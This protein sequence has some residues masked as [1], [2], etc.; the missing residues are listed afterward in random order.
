MYINIY[1]RIITE[2]VIL[3]ESLM[4]Q[5]R[6]LFDRVVVLVF[7]IFIMTSSIITQRLNAPIFLHPAYRMFLKYLVK[8]W[9][10]IL[11]CNSEEEIILYKP[12]QFKSAW[13]LNQIQ[14]R[15][16]SV[17]QSFSFVISVDRSKCWRWPPSASIRRFGFCRTRIL[18]VFQMRWHPYRIRSRRTST[19]RTGV[20]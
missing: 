18:T 10:Y 5:L 12:E 2:F 9:I 14:K 11:V 4:S 19:L 1:I 15:Y 16:I 3:I 20:A 8:L 7:D 13:T 6:K 17:L